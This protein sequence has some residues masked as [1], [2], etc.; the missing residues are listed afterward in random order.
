MRLRRRLADALRS[1]ERLVALFRRVGQLVVRGELGRVVSRVRPHSPTR[2]EYRAWRAAQAPLTPVVRDKWF[3]LALDPPAP[4]M[5]AAMIAAFATPP[6]GTTLVVQR[7]TGGGW[8]RSGDDIERPL[9]AYLRESGTAWICW[10]VDE[11]TPAFD[12][13][14]A[15]A[16]ACAVDGAR[17]V[18][19]D[20]ETAMAGLFKPAWD[21]EQ[22]AERDYAGPM[23]MV[24]GEL[25]DAVDAARASMPGARWAMLVDATSV[26]PEAAFV[27]MPRMLAIEHRGVPA[28][29]APA[30]R[31]A[32]AA[33]IVERGRKLRE[34]I[35]VAPTDTPW[36]RYRVPANGGV[37]IVIPTRDR[38]ELLTRCVEAIATAGL[39]RDAELVIVDNGS[40]E[41]AT[42]KLLDELR[43]QY[44]ASVV[45]MP[46]PFNF[47]ALCNAGVAAA[48]RRV[49]VLLNNDTMV[50]PGWLDELT[51]LAARPSI[52][53][54]GPLLLYPDGRIQSA[55]VLAGVNRTATSAL[56]GFARDDALAR[57]W[58]AARRRITAVMGACLAVERGKYLDTGGLDERFAVS[59]NEV[60]F[61]L[62]LEAAGLANLFTP[63]A[64]VVHEEGATRG[65]E[66][67]STERNRLAQEET[68]FRGRWGAI[69]AGVDPAHHPAFARSGNAFALVATPC[70]AAP[71]AGWRSPAAATVAG[72]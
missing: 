67:T 16:R 29:D 56:E 52:G 35:D 71:R 3:V 14:Q 34:D 5:R 57:D 2:A 58:C 6:S 51:S 45:P 70:E 64:H 48:R 17:I 21:R 27:H 8:I 25:A 37:S 65:F 39:P 7:G 33:R 55:G 15:F 44:A 24:H 62:R 68:L 53:A 54:V 42:A 18:Y 59:H 36:I 13:S 49:V 32:V 20:H 28:A 46:G 11:V 23:L 31:A 61:C 60:D 4:A 72:G 66:L 22:I 19:G 26:L 9:A 40:T 30:E 41:P 63:F 38:A 47:P 50:N 43:R 1:P 69:V 10:V 12:A